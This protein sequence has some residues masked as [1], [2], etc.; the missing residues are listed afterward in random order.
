MD[1]SKQQDP[2]LV[3]KRSID[4][5]PHK[6]SKQRSSQGIVGVI[7]V[8]EATVEKVRQAKEAGQKDEAYRALHY[9]SSYTCDFIVNVAAEVGDIDKNTILNKL[10]KST[11]SLKRGTGYKFQDVLQIIMNILFPN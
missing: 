9:P 10:P 3:A 2:Y 5:P 6:K 8:F 1:L 7:G 4:S 11:G